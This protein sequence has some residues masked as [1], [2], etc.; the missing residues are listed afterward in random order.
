MLMFILILMSDT[1]ITLKSHYRMAA[2]VISI[3]YKNANDIENMEAV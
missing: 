3:E 1:S 2:E